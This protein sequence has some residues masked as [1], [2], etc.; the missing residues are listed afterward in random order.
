MNLI[1][2]M[3]V[4]ISTYMF[5]QMMYSIS[6]MVEHMGEKTLLLVKHGYFVVVLTFYVCEFRNE[7]GMS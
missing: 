6:H 2:F 3:F 7:R 1:L 5:N 4:F